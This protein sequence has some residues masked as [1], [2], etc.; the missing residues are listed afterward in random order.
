M[1]TSPLTKKSIVGIVANSTS[2]G[3]FDFK[4]SVSKVASVISTVVISRVVTPLS[5]INWWIT[6][7]PLYLRPIEKVRSV[8][9][10]AARTNRKLDNHRW[11]Q[12]IL[13]AEHAS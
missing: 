8:Q 11:I 6:P 9:R 13:D 1:L 3:W 4:T 5:A 10:A 12:S 7:Q 2:T